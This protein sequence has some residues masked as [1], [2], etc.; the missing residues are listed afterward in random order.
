PGR[1]PLV[2]AVLFGAALPIAFAP[3]IS[4]T[5]DYYEMGSILVTRLAAACGGDFDLTRWRGDDLPKLAGE[6]AAVGGTAFDALGITAAFVVGCA[7]AW[8][9]Y[10]AGAV[11]SDT[12]ARIGRRR[13]ASAAP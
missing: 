9:T 10:A 1:T 13:A 8:L 2:Q 6:R 5:G 12:L 11:W 3:F 7:L 4:L